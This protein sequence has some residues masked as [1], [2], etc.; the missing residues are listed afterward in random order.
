LS[1]ELQKILLDAVEVGNKFWRDEATKNRENYYKNLQNEGMTI[2]RLTPE[3]RQ[4]FIAK[5]TPV[6]DLIAKQVGREL[7]DEL[8][9]AIDNVVKSQ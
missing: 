9:Q 8:F 5:V 7:V 6:V 3:E 2:I 4:A 1:P